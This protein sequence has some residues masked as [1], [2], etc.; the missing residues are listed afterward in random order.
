MV[1]IDTSPA[2]EDDAK[3]FGASTFVSDVALLEKGSLDMILNTASGRIPLDPFLEL[4]KPR[5]SLVCVS[6][7]DKEERSQ[8]YLHSAVP[9]ERALVGSYLGPL[10]DYEEMLAF[11]VEHDVRPQV[12]VMPLARINEAL[13]R[14]RD[15]KAR[16]R[17]VVE[18]P[19][20]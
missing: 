11:A 16:Y 10:G 15:G 14:V 20:F 8:L 9:T 19:E 1:A 12:E 6:L 2:K 18:M 4:L 3:K 7:P 17:V 13:T 5:G